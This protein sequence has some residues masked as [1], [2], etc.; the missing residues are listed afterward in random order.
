MLK[1][2]KYWKLSRYINRVIRFVQNLMMSLIKENSNDNKVKEVN[3]K[4]QKENKD[5]RRLQWNDDTNGNI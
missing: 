2:M 1:I 3:L 4:R 5:V